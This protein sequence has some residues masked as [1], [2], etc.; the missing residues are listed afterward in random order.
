MGLE[1]LFEDAQGHGGM[2]NGRTPAVWGDLSG[3]WKH[4]RR[5]SGNVQR[6]E[7]RLLRLPNAALLIDLHLP[8]VTK[9]C[10]LELR[11]AH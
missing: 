6:V 2:V 8:G 5:A 7:S 3:G 4:E 10:L 9:G 11:G 1:V